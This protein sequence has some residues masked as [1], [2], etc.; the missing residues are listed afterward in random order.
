MLSLRL[1]IVIVLLIGSL[2]TIAGTPES[3]SEVC[4][5][6]DED[7]QRHELHLLNGV[8][9]GP[10]M[11]WDENDNLIQIGFYSMNE[12]NAAWKQY[13]ANGDLLAEIQYVE[14]KRHGAWRFFHANGHIRA[15]IFY[16]SNEPIGHWSSFSEQQELIE[17]AYYE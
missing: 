5:W 17:Y 13:N 14:G 6:Q 12:K 1:H 16:E 9:H 15:E 7:G 8:K 10:Y 4:L 11:I 2:R 3:S